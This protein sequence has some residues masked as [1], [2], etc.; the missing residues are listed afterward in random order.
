MSRRDYSKKLGKKN[1][2]KDL[3]TSSETVEFL[4]ERN[5]CALFTTVTDIKK[6]PMNLIMGNLFDGKLLDLFEFEVTNFLP[7]EFFKV[8]WI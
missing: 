6:R 1:D 8:K 5:D 3:F 7:I 4:C 2:I